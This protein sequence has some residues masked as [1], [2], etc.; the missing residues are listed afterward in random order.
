[1]GRNAAIEAQGRTKEGVLYVQYYQWVCTSIIVFKG[2][3]LIYCS[4][5]TRARVYLLWVGGGRDGGAASI[6]EI[7]NMEKRDHWYQIIT[8][9]NFV[10]ISA[11]VEPKFTYC[12]LSSVGPAHWHV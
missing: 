5:N 11:F 4:Y 7:L 2:K 6:S 12:I 8:W 3:Y 1:M 10:K 9:Y